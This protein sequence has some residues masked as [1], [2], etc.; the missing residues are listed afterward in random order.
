MKIIADSNIPLLD[1]TFGQ[2]GRI[3]R[4]NGRAI[5]KSDLKGANVLL[6]RSVTRVDRSLLDGT[7]I[8]F[9]GSATIGTDHLDTKWL[10]KS[11]IQWASAPGC[12][13][14][15]AAQYSLA[16][17]ALSCQR[18]GRHLLNQSIGIIGLGNVGSRLNILLDALEISCLAHDP[19]LS[20]AGHNGLVGLEQVM[21]QDIVS[22]HVPLNR[23]GPY[24]SYRMINAHTLDLM[25]DQ[26]IILNTSRGN[27]IDEAALRACLGTGRI[28]AASD[29]WQD[30]PQINSETI[31]AC[32]V[33]SPH[34]AGYSIDGKKNGTL[35]IYEAF[36]TWAGL[37]YQTVLSADEHPLVAQLNGDSD[38]LPQLLKLCC[39]VE[40]DDQ[41]MRELAKLPVK[42]RAAAFDDIRKSYRPRRDFEAW[43]VY[44]ASTQ[45]RDMLDRLGFR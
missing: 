33:A 18:L 24:P 42:V 19:P 45:S 12:N 41:A 2:H 17:M 13:A 6:V 8:K 15:A 27:V 43:S 5:S 44:G 3:V 36:T 31:K 22:L 25:K 28:H 9:V 26:A 40:K 16:M 30:E 20:D 37:K 7:A 29:V 32:I 34:V 4:V 23:S 1:E 38:P 39:D 21:N 11:E 35:S 14:D 10:E